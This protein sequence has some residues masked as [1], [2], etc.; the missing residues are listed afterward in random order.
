MMKRESERVLT[1]AIEMETHAFMDNINHVARYAKN[2]DTSW[3][4]II[5]T[6]A[7]VSSSLLF[8]SENDNRGGII[9]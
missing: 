3:N 4:I 7:M 9:M 8:S 1:M 6:R 2:E 5:A